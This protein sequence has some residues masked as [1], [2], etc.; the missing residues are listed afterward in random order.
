VLL[1]LALTILAGEAIH[2][3][4]YADVHPYSYGPAK[5]IALACGAGA[6]LA[7]AA[8]IVGVTLTP[9]NTVRLALYVPML[10]LAVAIGIWL[11]TLTTGSPGDGTGL[12]KSGFGSGGFG[13]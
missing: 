7:L 8:G 3:L 10:L 2:E 12:G 5:V 1:V 4:H 6:V 11:V 13:G 9:K